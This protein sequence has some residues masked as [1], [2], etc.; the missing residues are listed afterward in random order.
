MLDCGGGGGGCWYTT[1]Q[2][3]EE[4]KVNNQ[5]SFL[6]YLTFAIVGWNGVPISLEMDI[7]M[8]K[9]KYYWTNIKC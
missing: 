5:K 4:N 2:K 9:W 8:N 6:G 1:H 7:S 3:E